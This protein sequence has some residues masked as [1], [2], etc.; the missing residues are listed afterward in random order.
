MAKMISRSLVILLTCCWALN[1]NAAGH[2]RH[3][4]VIA[5]ENKD[6][7]QAS[8]LSES[9]IYGN[10]KHAPYINKTLMPRA[11]WATNFNDELPNEN[12][13]PHYV[14]MEAGTTEF[15]DASFHCDSDP[16]QHCSGTKP[17]N[18][19]ANPA[20]LTAQIEAAGQSWMTYQ[21]GIDTR[22]TGACPIHSSGLYAA[23]HNPFVFFA[24]IA[25]NPPN[26]TSA[27]CIAH[28][29]DL[30]A[31]STDLA[32]DRL[33]D[34]VFITPNLCNDMHGAAQCNGNPIRT[35]D[36]FLKALLPP[37]LAWSA[38][39]GAVVL[40]T[41]DEGKRTPLLPFIMAGAGIKQNYANPALYSH[42]SIIKTV[43]L[44][45]GLP[46]LPAVA[47]ANDLSDFFEPGA[48]P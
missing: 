41:W 2:L 7:K 35:G 26:E 21:E 34:Y 44:I 1:A 48:F 12:S 6:A 5:M 25:G 15:Q 29:R 10:R 36:D 42:R 17:N 14:V 40:V 30:R 43:E 33:A 38:G 11:A 16:L 31:F 19:T 9:Y 39:N 45:F 4:I 18:W 8:A 20:H 37:L 22:H 32:A 24:D 46:V 23:K 13:E 28:T 3:V 47:D 27:P